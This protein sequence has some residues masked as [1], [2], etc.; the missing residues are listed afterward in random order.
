MNLMLPPVDAFISTGVVSMLTSNV[1]FFAKGVPVGRDRLDYLATTLGHCERWVKLIPVG[2]GK[3]QFCP[4][5]VQ[6]PV[7]A[8][9][10]N[11]RAAAL[12]VNS[13]V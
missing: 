3:K 12:P 11:P 1:A 13:I 4:L 7:R 9:L 10:V 6:S 5:V 8:A 2:L